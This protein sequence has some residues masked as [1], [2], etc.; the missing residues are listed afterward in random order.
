MPPAFQPDSCTVS[1]TYFTA[2]V[3]LPAQVNLPAYGAD[4]PPLRVVCQSPDFSFD[5]SFKRV[6]LTRQAATSAAVGHMLIG[7]GLIGAAV[8]ANAASQRDTSLDVY[9]YPLKIELQ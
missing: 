7:Y 6:N 4:T 3:D 5:K 8:T 2:E 9:G 1:S